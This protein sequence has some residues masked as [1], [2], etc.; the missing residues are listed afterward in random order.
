MNAANHAR[1]MSLPPAC[2]GSACQQGRCGS[3]MKCSGATAEADAA[4]EQFRTKPRAPVVHRNPLPRT[5]VP[6]YEI[7]GPD[8]EF[9]RQENAMTALLRFGAIPTLIVLL[10]LFALSAAI[11][12]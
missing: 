12:A 11:F 6:D 4:I 3:P 5:F 2:R 10:V 7:Q 9:M 1:V 8:S